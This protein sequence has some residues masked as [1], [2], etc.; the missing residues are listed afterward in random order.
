MSVSYYAQPIHPDMI[1]KTKQCVSFRCLAFP[2]WKTAFKQQPHISVPTLGTS[3]LWGSSRIHIRCHRLVCL[4]YFTGSLSSIL[5]PTCVSAWRCISSLRPAAGPPF[6]E[7]SVW[8]TAEHAATQ[9][10][11]LNWQR[12]FNLKSWYGFNTL[13]T[14]VNNFSIAKVCLCLKEGMMDPYII[15]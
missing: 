5:I 1:T 15:S 12:D 11:T 10:Y 2:K 14:E 7:V 9:H 13:Q 4:L 3:Y 8:F 6:A